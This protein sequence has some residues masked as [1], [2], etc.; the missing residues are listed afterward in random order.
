M[1]QSTHVVYYDDMTGEQIKEGKG[2][3]VTFALDGVEYVIDLSD[4]SANK[5]R[6]LFRS[7]SL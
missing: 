3:P 4:K 5:F 1:A 7:M 2:G 6:G